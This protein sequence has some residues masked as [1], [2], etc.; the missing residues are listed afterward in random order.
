M[1]HFI[2]NICN[3]NI[4]NPVVI[5]KAEPN[6]HFHKSYDL[7][8]YKG[9]Y[10]QVDNIVRLVSHKEFPGI[11]KDFGKTGLDFCGVRK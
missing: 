3:F 4:E 6:V 2:S 1:V 11:S 10:R 9:A 7:V 5:F 8:N